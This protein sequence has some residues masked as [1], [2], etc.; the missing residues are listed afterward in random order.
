MSLFHVMLSREKM[1]CICSLWTLHQKGVFHE[2]QLN[3]CQKLN[4]LIWMFTCRW[5]NGTQLNIWIFSHC[6]ITPVSHICFFIFS[7]QLMNN[8]L[9]LCKWRVTTHLHS[10]ILMLLRSRINSVD[11]QQFTTGSHCTYE[12]SN[13]TMMDSSHITHHPQLFLAA[14]TEVLIYTRLSG[15][16]CEGRIH[17]PA[18]CHAW[19]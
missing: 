3:N 1:C 5:G 19:S 16:K 18:I 15:R 10:N 11:F 17:S 14:P 12:C 9:P 13:Q 8:V 7:T 6:H 2:I 4:S